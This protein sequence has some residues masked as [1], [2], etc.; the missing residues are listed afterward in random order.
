MNIISAHFSDKV[1]SYHNN[2]LSAILQ[3][4]RVCGQYGIWN[5]L[6]KFLSDKLGKSWPEMY[7]NKLDP[8]KSLNSCE[9]EA[10]SSIYFIILT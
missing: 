9:F 7:V 4:A 6:Q 5:S 3:S 2:F 1:F 8:C 10:G